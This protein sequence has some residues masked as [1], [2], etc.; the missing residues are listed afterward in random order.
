[1]LVS[2]Q[3]SPRVNICYRSVCFQLPQRRVTAKVISRCPI[4]LPH[5][6]ALGERIQWCLE[7]WVPW[8]T[9]VLKYE[10][11]ILLWNQSPAPFY[12]YQQIWPS[13]GDLG[14]AFRRIQG[15]TSDRKGF[16]NWAISALN[17]LEY[18][19]YF[20]LISYLLLLLSTDLLVPYMYNTVYTRISIIS[21][22][23]Y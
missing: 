8:S 16:F 2:W 10:H 13:A 23:S 9:S 19:G 15:R 5:P 21:D 22:Q 18:S 1:M 4:P 11:Q 7:I 20:T 14:L 3:H 6:P 12:E 17:V